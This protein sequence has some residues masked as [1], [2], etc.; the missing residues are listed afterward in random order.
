ML[1]Q[2]QYWFYGTH[3]EKAKKLNAEFDADKHKLLSTAHEI[4]Q[5]AAIVGF[6]YQRKADLNKTGGADYSIFHGEISRYRDVFQFNYRLIMLLDTEYE[7]DENIRVD[8]AFRLI[9]TD[10]A[11][12]DEELYESYVRGGVDVLY[13]KLIEPSTSPDD[14]IKNL[15]DFMED[16]EDRYGH[17]DTDKIYDLCQIARS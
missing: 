6:I 15:Y 16:F 10:K 4:Y 5:L 9:G 3:A 13:E 12:A 8:K 11:K 17:Q 7:S 2:G 1:F 14:Y